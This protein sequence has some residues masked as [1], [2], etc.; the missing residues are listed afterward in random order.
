MVFPGTVESQSLARV[1]RPAIYASWPHLQS[2]IA[3]FSD[4]GQGVESSLENYL[5]PRIV[6]LLKAAI[7]IFLLYILF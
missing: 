6:A 3:Y 7:I 1:R 2:V 5:S 4:W